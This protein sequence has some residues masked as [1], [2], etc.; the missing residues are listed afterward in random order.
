L[1]YNA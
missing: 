1:G